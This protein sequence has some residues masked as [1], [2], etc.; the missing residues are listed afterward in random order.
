MP[1]LIVYDNVD[2]LGEKVSEILLKKIKE[3]INLTNNCIIALSGGETPRKSYINLSEKLNKVKSEV[4]LNNLKLIQVDE[5]WVNSNNE[6]SNQNMIKKCFSSI[7][8]HQNKF[9]AMPTPDNMSNIS[10]A[11]YQYEMRINEL[12]EVFHKNSIDLAILGMGDDGHTASLF[13]NNKEYEISLNNN[14]D[15]NIIFAQ[16]LSQSEF[17][18]TLTPRILI[19]IKNKILIITGEEKGKVYKRALTSKDPRIYPV[20]LLE[21]DS[22]TVYMDKSCHDAFVQ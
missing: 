18:I 19:P 1:E 15:K 7:K 16:V 12:F 9:L 10:E 4:D 11:V 2:V 22:L 14:F 20:C 5:R 8:N 21:D 13:P 17:R 3:I 6:R